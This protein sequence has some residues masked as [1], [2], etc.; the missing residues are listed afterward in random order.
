MKHDEILQKRICGC[1]KIRCESCPLLPDWEMANPANTPE[2]YHICR[3]TDH[4]I[5]SPAVS[6]TGAD[7]QTAK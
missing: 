6:C 3:K 1:I 2:G 5:S 7:D 4:P